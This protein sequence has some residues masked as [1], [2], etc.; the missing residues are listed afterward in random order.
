MTPADL[1]DLKSNANRMAARLRIMSHPE[2]LLMLC[3]MDEGEVSVSE[4]I[5]L[6]G[7]SQSAVSQHLAM[8]R[9]EDIVGIRAE[10]Q[11]RY[12]R[13]T[14]PVVRAIIHSLCEICA[15]AHA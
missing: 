6:T 8:L 10:A 14:D 15:E 3:R 13:L 5:A 7:L 12:Y 11:V 2:R 9:D 1:T 4:L